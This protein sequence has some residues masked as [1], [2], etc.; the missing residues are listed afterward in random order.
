MKWKWR[1][2]DKGAHAR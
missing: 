2:V 1:S